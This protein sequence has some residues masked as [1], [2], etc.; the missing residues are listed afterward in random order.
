[1]SAQTQR[2]D[3]GGQTAISNRPATQEDLE[4]ELFRTKA[5]LSEATNAAEI[6]RM[7]ARIKELEDLLAKKDQDFKKLLD[8]K[9]KEESSTHPSSQKG[10]SRTASE[11]EDDNSSQGQS[12]T[13]A[14]ST[15]SQS[16][17]RT[18][19]SFSGVGAFSGLSSSSGNGNGIGAPGKKGSESQFNDALLAKYGI[20]IDQKNYGAQVVAREADVDGLVKLTQIYEDQEKSTL[21]SAVV[22]DS[23]FEKMK[24]NDLTTLASLY[25]KK[26]KKLGHQITKLKISSETSEGDSLEYYVIKEGDQVVFQPV[27]RYTRESLMEAITH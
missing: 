17:S 3:E 14:Q 1:M 11:T 9:F 5:D 13:Q 4:E 19:A 15:S 18:P 7:N 27:R 16:L 20:M 21:V 22:S 2:V 23:Q 25:N 8:D 6:Q 10:A 26:I 12:S 24:E